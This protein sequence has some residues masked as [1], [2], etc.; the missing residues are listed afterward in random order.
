M[1]RFY[2]MGA[3]AAL[4]KFGRFLGRIAPGAREAAYEVVQTAEKAMPMARKA[5]PLSDEAKKRLNETLAKK[6]YLPG[7]SGPW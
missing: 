2:A 1:D 3:Q 6:R 7:S 5:K 4:A